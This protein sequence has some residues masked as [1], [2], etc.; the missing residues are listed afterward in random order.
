L[1]E[2]NSNKDIT[3]VCVAYK[4]H[5]QI[6]VL[7]HSI[8]CQSLQNLKLHIIHDGYDQEMDDLLRP[9]QQQHPEISYEFTP[10]RHNDYGHSLREIGIEKVDTEYHMITNDDHYY[11]PDSSN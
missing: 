3:I 4:R 8:I 10:S 2:L 1:S 6:P 7:I 9:Y 11:V 5:A